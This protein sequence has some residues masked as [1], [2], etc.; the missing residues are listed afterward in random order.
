MGF[1]ITEIYALLTAK[2]GGYKEGMVN[3]QAVAKTTASTLDRVQE[4]LLR[5]TA[6]IGS[7][8]VM[9]HVMAIE[10]AFLGLKTALMATGQE[11]DHNAEKAMHLAKTFS[12]LTGRAKEEYLKGAET[13]ALLGVPSEKIGAMLRVGEGLAR[14]MGT[15]LTQGIRAATQAQEGYYL[16]LQR[17]LPQLREITDAHE[18]FAYTLSMARTGW[19]IAQIDSLSKSL[20][21][22][23]QTFW[24]LI[25]EA[26]EPLLPKISKF[27]RF[28]HEMVQPILAWARAHQT[29][30]SAIVGLTVALGLLAVALPTLKI[31]AAALGTILAALTLKSLAITAVI[32]AIAYGLMELT[33]VFGSST[34]A[35]DEYGRAMT[36][37]TDPGKWQNFGQAV[38]KGCATASVAIERIGAAIGWV[39]N[40][41]QY[42]GYAIERNFT[43][44]G[45]KT[46]WAVNDEINK[47]LKNMDVYEKELGTTMAPLIVARYKSLIGAL[48]GFDKDTGDTDL[49]LLKKSKLSG[50]VSQFKE[51]AG[52]GL[53]N[54][55]WLNP[56]TKE[57]SILEA[58]KNSGGKFDTANEYLRR[59]SE[60][61]PYT[62]E[63]LK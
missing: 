10:E 40:A 24:N 22:L 59:I 60:K 3:A 37:A 55:N 63:D 58:I 8:Y 35:V 27:I 38:A 52:G 48:G 45:G 26:M 19:S 47:A 11:V 33:G 25:W 23:K 30:A 53:T 44:V 57:D 31:A 51:F 34:D 2:D 14:I 42:M 41:Y 56:M 36:Q 17:R 9:H 5:V 20:G 32:A 6:G 16:M 1:K 15:D 49:D 54:L 28:L 7:G 29:A 61:E 4:A 50:R 62:I 39:Y 43:E 46:W 18:K 21:I 13:A 12:E